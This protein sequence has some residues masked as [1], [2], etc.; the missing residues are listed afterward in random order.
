M[1]RAARG[2]LAKRVLAAADTV[3]HWCREDMQS[4]VLGD[5]DA[6]DPTAWRESVSDLQ[7]RI[8]DALAET[9]PGIFEFTP[10]RSEGLGTVRDMLTAALYGTFAPDE[11][12]A[13][14]LLAGSA[15]FD[16]KKP[17][18]LV[19]WLLEVESRY[20]LVGSFVLVPRAAEIARAW[21]SETVRQSLEDA[22][23]IASP[24]LG[25][26]LY[27]LLQRPT[28]RPGDPVTR[29]RLPSAW[30]AVVPDVTGRRAPFDVPE[31]AEASDVLLVTW[32]EE[33]T[34]DAERLARWV[35]FRA[36]TKSGAPWPYSPR[37]V[38]MCRVH[39]PR[40]VIAL[41][42]SSAN[43]AALRESIADMR[44]LA[45]K[46][47]RHGESRE[48][49]EHAAR[50]LPS[51]DEI[52]AVFGVLPDATMPAVTDERLSRHPTR[53]LLLPAD[54]EE[55]LGPD[56]PIGAAR[57]HCARHGLEAAEQFEAA[58]RSYRAERRLLAT[59]GP[60]GPNSMPPTSQGED[61]DWLR[62]IAGV[63]DRRMLRQPLASLRLRSGKPLNRILTALVSDE[64]IPSV[65]APIAT[66]PQSLRR[67]LRARGIGMASLDSLR[68][69]L[70][71]HAHRWRLNLS[72]CT[73]QALAEAETRA[74]A[75]GALVDSL[76]D[77]AR[78]FE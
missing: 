60:A 63:F 61:S 41:A 40:A 10:R 78:L 36:V 26:E 8:L 15:A 54:L 19:G 77:L 4:V 18:L 69:A 25:W 50:G 30:V 12:T 42:R 37:T 16:P 33:T 74:E 68:E 14:H 45:G 72:G 11:L 38:L 51:V 9:A 24:E 52:L 57:Q 3:F 66:L 71:L 29:F 55:A 47:A 44:L 5:V 65:D 67:L 23:P 13:V 27:Q 28:G 17:A 43:L 39:E 49:M 53:L 75:A 59:W 20:F 32:Y 1:K 58:W 21:V 48:A 73:P 56:T 35:G 7:W 62:P 2:K 34:Y 46:G 64:A 31:T 22:D 76:D 6:V 70:W